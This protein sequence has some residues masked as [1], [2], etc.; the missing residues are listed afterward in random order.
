MVETTKTLW[1]FC[2]YIFAKLSTTSWRRTRCRQG[3]SEKKITVFQ[4]CGPQ[5]P[6]RQYSQGVDGETGSRVKLIQAN[7]S[8]H[9]YEPQRTWETISHHILLHMHRK[10]ETKSVQQW[11][12]AADLE[13]HEVRHGSESNWDYS[14][15]IRHRQGEAITFFYGLQSVLWTFWLTYTCNLLTPLLIISLINWQKTS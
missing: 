5:G 8:N 9:G 13:N 1:C 4:I 12:L 3:G 10:L 14:P 2:L 15:K 11:K 6:K 7:E